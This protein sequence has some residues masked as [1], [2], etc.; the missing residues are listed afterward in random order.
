M[1]TDLFSATT[2]TTRRLRIAVDLDGLDIADGAARGWVEITA[3]RP[4]GETVRIAAP[5]LRAARRETARLRAE[6]HQGRRRTAGVAV[7]VDLEAL[8]AEQAG[9]ARAQMMRHDEARG[10]VHRGESLR[11]VGTPAGLAG[12]IGDIYA[13]DV[14]DGVTLR[15]LSLA[16]LDSL[17]ATAPPL[18]RR[19]GLTLDARRL[20]EIG[21]GR[22]ER[23]TPA[24]V[25][26]PRHGRVRSACIA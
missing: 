6:A 14:A 3:D 23:G 5:D 2:S 25:S 13:A 1:S 16:T 20:Q 22:I 10:V 26:T 19:F 11:Y 7:L 12:L 15:P 21:A 24:C 17:C 9:T 8:T 18:L 4:P